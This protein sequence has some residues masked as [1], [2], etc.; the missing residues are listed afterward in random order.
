[1]SSL[2]S[3]LG[4]LGSIIFGAY[5]LWN[6]I[7]HVFLKTKDLMGYAQFKGVPHPQV[8]VYATGI[9][10]IVGGLGVITQMYT[11]IALWCLAIFLI[12]TSLKMH[13]FW[14]I[15]DPQAKMMEAVQFGKNMALL[16]A[17]LSM[18]Y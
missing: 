8:A 14:S 13:A 5:F 2:Y 17:V 9:L 10:L 1:M 12:G 18:M 11:E 7:K 4:Q 6:G 16:G 15:Q 3:S